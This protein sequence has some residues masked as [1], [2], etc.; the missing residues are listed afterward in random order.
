LSYRV[1]VFV[2]INYFTWFFRTA[3]EISEAEAF[4]K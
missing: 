2:G 3:F 4:G 1:K